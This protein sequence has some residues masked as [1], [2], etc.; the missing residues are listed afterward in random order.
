MLQLSLARTQLPPL[1]TSADPSNSTRCVSPFAPMARSNCVP[2]TP[3][4]AV[5]VLIA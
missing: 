2:R 3:I 4:V 1:H 5:G